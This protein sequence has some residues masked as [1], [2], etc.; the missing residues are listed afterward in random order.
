MLAPCADCTFQLCVHTTDR[1]AD[2]DVYWLTKD[3]LPEGGAGGV[4]GPFAA[5]V[6]AV[7]ARQQAPLLRVQ[8]LAEQL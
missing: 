4:A 5:C 6:H 3:V 8:V 7:G 1:G 2:P